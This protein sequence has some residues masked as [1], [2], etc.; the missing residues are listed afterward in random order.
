MNNCTSH[1]RPQPPQEACHFL[2]TSV[3]F[4]PYLLLDIAYRATVHSDDAAAGSILWRLLTLA[5]WWGIYERCM[6]VLQARM[7]MLTTA[8]CGKTFPQPEHMRRHAKHKHNDPADW[9]NGDYSYY[10][11][12]PAASYRNSSPCTHLCPPGSAIRLPQ[13]LRMGPHC[14]PVVSFPPTALPLWVQSTDSCYAGQSTEWKPAVFG[15]SLSTA[16][17]IIDY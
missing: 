1:G 14:E 2:F 9:A 16:M 11:H 10:D 12:H 4:R 6:G 5:N 7:S 17:L 15:S 3:A 8:T 13:R